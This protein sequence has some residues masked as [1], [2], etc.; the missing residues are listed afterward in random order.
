MTIGEYI[1][2]KRKEAGLSAEELGKKIGKNR[3][4]IYRYENNSIEKLPANVLV[5]L[6]NALSITPGELIK[7][8]GD[9]SPSLPAGTFKPVFK[10]VPLLGY[11]AAGKPLDDL[12]QDVSYVDVDGK[13]N[14]DFAV[15]VVGDSMID[16]DINDGD[17][18]FAKSMPEVENGQI[19]VVEI[20]HEKACLKRFY[21]SNDTITLISANPK[22]PPMVFN[23]E[24]CESVTVR[25]LAV[26]KQSEIR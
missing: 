9:D 22:Y 14:V 3:A 6:A 15:K 1:R 2:Q 21:R 25:G 20:D 23:A 11:V 5:P 13:Y 18:V 17:I 8:N 24:N 12:N 26:I 19:A 10:K 16:I 7:R 4:T